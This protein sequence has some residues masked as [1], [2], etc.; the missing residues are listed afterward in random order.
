MVLRPEV[1]DAFKVIGVPPGADEAIASK[2]Y[3]QLALRHHPDRNK[4]DSTSTARFQEVCLS[5]F[6]Y[7][8]FHANGLLI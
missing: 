3:K 2:A 6:F 7:P 5:Y 8:A 1:I 4:G